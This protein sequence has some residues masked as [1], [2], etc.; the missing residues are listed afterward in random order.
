MLYTHELCMYVAVHEGSALE[1]IHSVC[2]CVCLS[3]TMKSAAYL[4][5]TSQ[6]KVFYGA[7]FQRFYHLAFLENAS[8]QSSGAICWSLLPSSLPGELSMAKRNSDGFFS[9]FKV[10]GWLIQQHDWFIIDRSALVEKL[11]CILCML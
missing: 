5:F 8:F 2:V 9:T 10:H 1:C 3:A 6:I 7:C 11:L 4:V